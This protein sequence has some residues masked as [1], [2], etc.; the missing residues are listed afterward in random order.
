[1]HVK[2]SILSIL[3][4]KAQCFGKGISPIKPTLVKPG[5]SVGE[6]VNYLIW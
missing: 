2:H 1:M 6:F 4:I 5:N 3:F